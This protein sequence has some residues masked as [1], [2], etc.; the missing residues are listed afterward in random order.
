MIYSNPE[1]SAEDLNAVLSAKRLVR[2]TLWQQENVR[3]FKK[4]VDDESEEA[5]KR[6]SG[7]CGE[8]EGEGEG[9]NE[10]ET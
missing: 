6:R 10:K 3:A 1:H 9:D 7:D 2:R 8:G 4:F 5:K